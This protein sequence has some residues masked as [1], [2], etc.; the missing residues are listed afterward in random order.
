MMADFR[1]PKVEQLVHIIPEYLIIGG[2]QNHCD[3]KT[4][5]MT[6]DVGLKPSLMSGGNSWHYFQCFELT[7]DGHFCLQV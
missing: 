7:Q 5:R 4:H 6:Q 3:E 1:M 2:E